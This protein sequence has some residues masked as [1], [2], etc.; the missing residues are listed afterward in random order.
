MPTRPSAERLTRFYDRIGTRGWR[1]SEYFTFSVSSPAYRRWLGS[2]L[3]ARRLQILSIGCGTGELEKHLCDLH[4]RV[5]GLDPFQ[6]MLQRARENGVELLVLA[7]ALRLPFAEASFD[8]VMF[9]ESV[10]Y[11]RLPAAFEEARRVL[12]ANGRLLVTTYSGDVE[13]HA[14]YAKLG[15][16][17]IAPALTTAGFPVTDHRF[18]N[19]KRSS[20]SDV[21]SDDESNVLL[22]SARKPRQA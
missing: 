19:A 9:V 21:A 16:N 8:V 22:V 1:N 14:S 12:K 15:L 20:V 18:L 17:E 5:V 7:D 2:Q 4:H 10:G 13:V 6:P 11:L 3:G